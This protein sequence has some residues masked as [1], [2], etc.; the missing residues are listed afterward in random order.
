EIGDGP[1]PG[2]KVGLFDGHREACR[3]SRFARAL[4]ADGRK[5]HGADLEALPGEP[6][7]V[8][9]VAIARNK[10]LA[11]GS[12][13]VN[14]RAQIGVGLFAVHRLRLPEAFVPHRSEEHT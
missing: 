3:V 12:E 2:G 14:L 6:E 11:A 4:H 8:A 13:A 5:I 9:A 7:T 1:S 10:N